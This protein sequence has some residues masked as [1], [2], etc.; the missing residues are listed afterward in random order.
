[1]LAERLKLWLVE[2]APNTVEK[3]DKVV[4]C[5]PSVGTGT[6]VALTD[7]LV[8]A[9]PE[10]AVTFPVRLRLVA[11]PAETRTNMFVLS[12]PPGATGATSL[13][14]AALVLVKATWKPA[15]AVTVTAEARLLPDKT[16]LVAGEAV[17]VTVKKLVNEPGTADSTG[18]GAL[19][20]PLTDTV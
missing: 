5:A 15:G 8:G 19:I 10:T 14:K 13:V 20:V 12:K 18:A 6:T 9:L 11:A 1:M 3:L 17:P 4:G 2:A 7:T 16:K